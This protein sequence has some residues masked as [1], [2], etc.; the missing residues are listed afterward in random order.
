MPGIPRQWLDSIVFL[1]PS[2]ESA[3]A[4]EH[5]GGTG[6]LLLVDPSPGV[7]VEA[8]TGYFVTNAHVIEGGC[9]FVRINRHGRDADVF[10]VPE[11]W[12]LHPDGDDLAVAPVWPA[13][14][15]L[16]LN[17]IPFGMAVTRDQLDTEQLGP[18]DEAF[19]IGRFVHRDGAT[20]NTPTARF[21]AI[22]QVGGDPI[23]Q[24]GRGF[25]QESV[26]VECHSLS[27][28]SGSPVFAYR[29]ANFRNATDIQDAV[30]GA[31]GVWVQGRYCQVFLLGVDWGSDNWTADVRDK[32]TD[33]PI[34]DQYVRASSG[35]AMVV[36]AWKLRGVLDHP[37]LVEIQQNREERFTKKKAQED[38]AVM[39]SAE[40]PTPSM[41]DGKD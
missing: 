9:R 17:A 7:P 33:K 10:E 18:G 26:L 21:G 12:F 40:A 6:F 38:P 3:R 34:D 13:D 39:D 8:S 37:D 4:G 25:R 23:F 36:P 1:Y 2:E 22:A 27:G 41:S 30:P 24:K 16:R 15:S 19:F 29:S 5:Y 28:F 20:S 31:E 35:M 11:G 14:S 32:R